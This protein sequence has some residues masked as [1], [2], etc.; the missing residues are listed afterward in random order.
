[1][2]ER[3]FEQLTARVKAVEERL[4]RVEHPAEKPIE[5]TLA[6]SPDDLR[7][8]ILSMNDTV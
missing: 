2:S 1:M 4:D 8:C 3:D 7:R 6:V 5:I